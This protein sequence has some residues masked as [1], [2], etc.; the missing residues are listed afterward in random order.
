MKPQNLTEKSVSKSQQKFMGMVHA[1]QK[2]GKCASPAVEK[3]AKSMKKKDAKDFA[4]TKHKGLPEHKH[5]KFKEWLSEK[6][7]EFFNESL[8]PITDLSITSRDSYANT[9]NWNGPQ[10][11]WVKNRWLEKCM[12]LANNFDMDIQKLNWSELA[13]YFTQGL[14]PQEALSRTLQS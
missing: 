10:E 8:N 5:K 9:G 11:N 13:T 2:E 7:P 4:E 12:E 3:V 14:N 1:C 6:H